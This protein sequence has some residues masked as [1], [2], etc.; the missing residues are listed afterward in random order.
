VTKFSNAFITGASSGIG[1]HVARGLA[2]SGTRV[3]VA[4][5]REPEL[6]ALVEL[7]RADG[8]KADACVLDVGDA[9]AV[10]AAV[11]AWDETTGGLDLVVAN[12]GMGVI[13]PAHKLTW[14][15]VE[16]VLRV[17]V[18][19]A[20]CT[21][22]AGMQV[23][24]PRKRGT[25]AGVS[26]LAAMRGLPKSGAYAASK[27]ALATFLETMRIDLQRKGIT[28]VDVR[29]GFVDTPMTRPNKVWMPQ[30]MDVQEAAR[31][32]VRGIERGSAIVSCPRALSAAMSLTESMPDALYRAVASRVRF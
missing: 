11:Q 23:M 26:S 13:K 17:N 5:R 30:L 7:I 6:Q 3:V 25:L 32:I 4:A 24:L 28:V 10:T 8:G 12:A 16:P 22:L 15:T 20:F 14:Q 21:L 9:D 1:Y 27:A 18:M 19:G 2:R 31:V 29:P